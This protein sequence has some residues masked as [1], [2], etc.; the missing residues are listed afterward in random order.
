MF[1]LE[2]VGQSPLCLQDVTVCSVF[3]LLFCVAM[4][5]KGGMCLK[6]IQPLLKGR[7]RAVIQAEYEERS[8]ASPARGAAPLTFLVANEFVFEATLK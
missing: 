3:K 4:S 5:A 7:D 2:Y 1:Y 6:S 8:A